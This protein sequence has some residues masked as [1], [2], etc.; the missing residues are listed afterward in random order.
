M[1]LYET[2]YFTQNKVCPCKIGSESVKKALGI[3]NEVKDITLF[4]EEMER[5]RVIGKHIW[6]DKEENT[7]FITKI[8]ASESG[9]G[10][11]ENKSLIGE[12]CHCEHYNHSKEY[13]PKYYCKCGAEFYRPMFAP[14]FGNDVLIEPYKTVLSGDDECILAVRID[15]KEANK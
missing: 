12:R 10:C 5:Q 11:S 6:Y 15:K 4:A 2:H 8:Y 3:Y 14:L 13:K 1:E 7:I 9:G